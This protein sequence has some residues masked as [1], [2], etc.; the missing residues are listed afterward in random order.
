[1][2]ATPAVATGGSDHKEV[3]CH[4]VN[5]KGE[6][7]YG[8]DIIDVDKASSHFDEYGKPK[9]ESNDGR[10]DTYAVGGL[11]PG[12]PAPTVTATEKP[13]VTVT[14][15]AP[16]ETVTETTT[17]TVKVTVTGPP[18]TETVRAPGETTTSTVTNPPVEK[19]VTLPATTKTVQVPGEQR[20]ETVPGPVTTNYVTAAGT[21]KTAVRSGK[22]TLAYT[23]MDIGVATLGFVLFGAGIFLLGARRKLGQH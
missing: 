23:G 5:G 16:V 22:E 11:C 9:H 10:T 12:A 8:W 1:M 6:T 7:G 18:V 20:T 14:E 21:T 17:P 19:T 15:T 2:I 4:P 13:T 3:I